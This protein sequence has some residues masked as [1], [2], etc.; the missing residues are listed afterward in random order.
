[1]NVPKEIGHLVL[2]VTDVKKSTIFYRDVVGFRVFRY[3]PDG[4]GT[5]FTCGV[6]HHNLA[7]G[8]SACGSCPPPAFS[9]VSF[10]YL[11]G[12]L[13]R[14][15]YHRLGEYPIA[16]QFSSVHPVNS[17]KGCGLQSEPIKLFSDVNFPKVVQKRLMVFV[18]PWEITPLDSIVVSP[19]V[20]P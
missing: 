1:M 6:V 10:L 9:S 12:R 13:F 14:R 11:N 16:F 3:R 15:L 20:H 2:N 17:F 18:A 19:G 7:Q 5:F 4:K 8:G